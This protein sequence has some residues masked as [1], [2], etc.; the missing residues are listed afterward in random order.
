MPPISACDDEDG[1]PNHQVIRFHVMAPMRPAKIAV[2]VT[3]PAST[4]PLATVAATV[5]EMKAPTKLR[6][7]ATPTAT[8]GFSAPVAMVVAIALAVSWKPFVKSN[9]SAT[10]TTRT[11]MMSSVTTDDDMAERRYP[12]GLVHNSATSALTGGG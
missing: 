6:I 5:I 2:G 12:I 9:T 7:A 10:A 11:T 4:I 3:T 1:M 8:F